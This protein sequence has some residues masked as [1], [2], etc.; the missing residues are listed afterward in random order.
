MG[1]KVAIGSITDLSTKKKFI[2]GLPKYPTC[3]L[4]TVGFNF[5]EYLNKKKSTNVTEF[6]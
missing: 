4:S 6:I 3:P 1:Q 2:S 5:Q